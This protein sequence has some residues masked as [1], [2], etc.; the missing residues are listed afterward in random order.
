MKLPITEKFLLDVYSHIEKLDETFTIFSYRKMKE[1]C[2]PSLYE[3]RQQHKR[4]KTKQEFSQ[5][6]YYLK[7]K[8]YIKIKNLEQN[9]GVVLT[10]KGEEKVLRIKFKIRKKEERSDKKWQMIIFDIPEK[11]RHLRDLL[12]DKLYLLEYKMLQ[13]SIWVCPYNVAKETEFILRKYSLDPY[14]K[15]F[16]IE[17]I[18]I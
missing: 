10:K 1:Y 16:L 8:G 9:K 17:E 14:V 15:L 5:L 2:H 13:Q 3:L 12:R 7:K 18:E 6:V 11:K 4:R